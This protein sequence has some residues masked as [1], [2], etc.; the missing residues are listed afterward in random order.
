M[1]MTFLAGPQSFVAQI[2]A[3]VQNFAYLLDA[4]KRQPRGSSPQ[5]TNSRFRSATREGQDHGVQSGRV[6]Q[7]AFGPHRRRARAASRR[8][9]RTS[10]ASRPP[11]LAVAAAAASGRDRRRALP[12]A[13][14]KTEFTVVLKGGGANKIGVIK[15]VREVTGLG[16]FG[17]LVTHQ[18]PHR[19]VDA[20]GNQ[21]PRPTT[22][23]SKKLEDASPS[24][25]TAARISGSF[26]ALRP[27]ALLGSNAPDGRNDL[28][29]SI[30]GQGVFRACEDVAVLVTPSFTLEQV[31]SCL[32]SCCD[33][34][35]APPNPGDARRAVLLA[36]RPLGVCRWN[37][38]RVMF[39]ERDE[40]IARDTGE[41]RGRL[42]A[43]HARGRPRGRAR[44]AVPRARVARSSLPLHAHV[45]RLAQP[46]V[47]EEQV[48]D[49]ARPRM[50]REVLG[51][52][53]ATRPAPSRSPIAQ[54]S[55]S[56]RAAGW[57]GWSSLAPRPRPSPASL[58]DRSAALRACRSCATSWS[59]D[60]TRARRAAAHRRPRAR[61]AGPRRLRQPQASCAGRVDSAAW[62]PGRDPSAD[63]RART[64]APRARHA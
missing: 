1:L 62:P 37:P 52:P 61:R 23:G 25:P 5:S 54:R 14:E 26:R 6:H 11:R 22:C 43:R 33:L 3:P 44:A 32:A 35:G 46:E 4:R 19:S 21:R 51:L 9:S 39:V 41:S 55:G 36:R 56:P 30:G 49:R 2:N 7:P 57:S 10:G 50:A 18:R 12:Q 29:G 64:T 27:S 45:A 59:S 53:A 48:I 20:A 17:R 8:P 31:A 16:P 63:R 60:P 47:V 38:S 13:E 40:E 28:R 42:R 15:V 58:T 34:D 24:R